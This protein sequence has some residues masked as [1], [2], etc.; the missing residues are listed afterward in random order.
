MELFE[1][2]KET[3]KSYEI[4]QFFAFDGD[5]VITS[6]PIVTKFELEYL[7]EYV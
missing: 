3:H 1:Q 6:S 7:K 5:D 4:R 2:A